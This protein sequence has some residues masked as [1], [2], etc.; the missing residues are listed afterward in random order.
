[1]IDLKWAKAFELFGLFVFDILWLI[2][3]TCFNDWKSPSTDFVRFYQL[4]FD[5]I[6]DSACLPTFIAKTAEIDSV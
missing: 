3:I 2:R 5:M 1:M 6:A 4:N